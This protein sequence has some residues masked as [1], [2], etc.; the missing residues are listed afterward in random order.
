MRQNCTFCITA[1][2][3]RKDAN[4]TWWDHYHQS[5]NRNYPGNEIQKKMRKGDSIMNV[6]ISIVWI[7][8]CWDTISL[9]QTCK[10]GTFGDRTRWGG[11]GERG[12]SDMTGVY[13]DMALW[14]SIQQ[15]PS[16]QR[17]QMP[18]DPAISFLW[19]LSYM[20]NH[21]HMKWHIYKV[22]CCSVVYNSQMLEII[23]ITVK[24]N[25]D[26]LCILYGK[27][28]KVNYYSGKSKMQS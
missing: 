8:K 2:V 4:F 12:T 16:K 26:A 10:D 18:F 1:F 25:E 3:R 23:E 7:E 6:Y 20:D 24:I 15:H 22:I 17:M 27:F 13:A 28:S 21:K 11:P 9:H 19:N 5:N 14:R